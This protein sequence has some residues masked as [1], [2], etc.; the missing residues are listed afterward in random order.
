MICIL[1]LYE[2]IFKD[3]ESSLSYFGDRRTDTRVD[4]KFQVWLNN[5]WLVCIL[6][7]FYVFLEIVFD[8]SICCHLLQGVETAS[9]IRY[10]TYYEKLLQRQGKFFWTTDAWAEIK[11]PDV[12]RLKMNKIRI[13]GRRWFCSYFVIWSLWIK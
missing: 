5:E 9:Q 2:G 10:V 12:V 7:N 8:L 6:F 3:A 1:N 11:C 13:T 4:Q